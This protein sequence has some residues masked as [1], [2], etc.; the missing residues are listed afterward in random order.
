MHCRG[1]G[2]GGRR[3]ACLGE[4]PSG[5]VSALLLL[6]LLLPPSCSSLLLLLSPSLAPF[7]PPPS[8]SPHPQSLTTSSP[9]AIGHAA[10]MSS[11]PGTSLPPPAVAAAVPHLVQPGEPHRSTETPADSRR[12]PHVDRPHAGIHLPAADPPPPEPS[13][14]PIQLPPAHRKAPPKKG[15]TGIRTQ[16]SAIFQAVCSPGRPIIIGLRRSPDRNRT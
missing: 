3:E 14:W 10:W 7:P 16:I 9:P 12:C 5:P 1:G 6:L 11:L 2:E 15:R 8:S 13:D 4:P